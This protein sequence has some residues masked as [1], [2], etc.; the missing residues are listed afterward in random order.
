MLTKENRMDIIKEFGDNEQDS[1]NSKV[2]IAIL[3]AR[4]KYLTEH[5]KVNKKD[6]HSRRGMRIMLGKRGRL[7]R[8]LKRVDLTGYRGL[9][10]KLSLKDR[11]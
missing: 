2:Q 9:I 11:Y 8:Y 1:G 4:V 3:S 10:E 5:L 6:V 7:L